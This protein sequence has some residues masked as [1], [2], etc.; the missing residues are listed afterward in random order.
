[1]WP[2]FT[3]LAARRRPKADYWR[4]DLAQDRARHRKKGADAFGFP[5]SCR[6]STG[7]RDIVHRRIRRSSVSG[8]EAYGNH[9]ADKARPG[10][11]LRIDVGVAPGWQARR[12]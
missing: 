7:R 12:N 4:E 6:R 1:M 10:G 2:W 5:A 9:K 3:S 8:F 11:E